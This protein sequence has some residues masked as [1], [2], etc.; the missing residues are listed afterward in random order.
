MSENESVTCPCT[1]PHLSPVVHITSCPLAPHPIACAEDGCDWPVDVESERCG[2]HSPAVATYLVRGT[3]GG[4][5][6]HT[7]LQLDPRRLG[8]ELESWRVRHDLTR[9]LARFLGVTI[10][11]VYVLDYR[12]LGVRDDRPNQA[13]TQ[14]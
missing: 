10:F 6:V 9:A 3:V 2:W 5:E 7:A 12:L 13:S 8:W 11:D 14:S 4:A 1:D